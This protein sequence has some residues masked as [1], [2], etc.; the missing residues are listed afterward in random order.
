MRVFGL[1]FCAEPRGCIPHAEQRI[2]VAISMCSARRNKYK[3]SIMGLLELLNLSA[4][5]R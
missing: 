4:I 1:P 3:N 5:T 2:T